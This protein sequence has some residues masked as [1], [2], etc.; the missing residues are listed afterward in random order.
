MRFLF[1]FGVL[2][3]IASWIIVQ[4]LGLFGKLFVASPYEVLIALVDLF[5][6]KNSIIFD[7]ISTLIR[8][9]AGFTI[10]AAIGIPVGI[11]MGYSR[12]I[13]EMFQPLV[14]FLRSIPATALFPLFLLFFGIND[15]SKIAVVVYGSGLIII[16]NAMYG[17]HHSS[18]TRTLYAKTLNASSSQIFRKIIFF[19]ALPH[20]FVGLR[21]ALSISLILVIVTEMF[22]GTNSGLGQKIFDFHLTYKI[23]EMF[24]AIIISGIIGY[25]L[26]VGFLRFEKRIIHWVGKS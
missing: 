6:Q 1:I 7:I 19:E 5:G 25:L 22:V 17:V 2:I 24:A 11:V 23:P 15:E 14:D 21:Q 3:I 16:I 12:T 13:Y 8:M 9:S 26:N 10:A 18:K 20:V 4:S